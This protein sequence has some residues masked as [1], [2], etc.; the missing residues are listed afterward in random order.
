MAWRYVLFAIGGV[1]A[2]ALVGVITLTLLGV[3]LWGPGT[4][5]APADPPSVAAPET[6]ALT[7]EQ[8]AENPADGD[9]PA[10]AP[11]LAEDPEGSQAGTGDPTAPDAPPAEPTE[12][13]NQPVA[14]TR[15][16][17]EAPPPAIVA[18]P[19]APSFD[20]VRV[21]SSRT[22]VI[23]GRANPRDR[24]TVY[25][26]ETALGS[27]VAD[28]RGE[29][30]VVPGEAL[31]PGDYSLTLEAEPADGD[32]IL[33]SQTEVLLVVPEPFSDV[34]GAQ[35]PAGSAA[36]ALEV[37]RGGAAGAEVLQGPGGAGGQ[38]F[39][40]QSLDITASDALVVAGTAPADSPVII[41]LDGAPMGRV[42][43]DAEGRWRWQGE[44]EI[45]GKTSLI[46]AE[47]ELDGRTTR[48][49]RRID[50]T[51]IEAALPTGRLV[52]VQPGNN[53]WRIARRT[54][55]EGLNYT[56][57][58]EANRDRIENP[59]LIFPGQAFTI[60]DEALPQ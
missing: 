60:P 59:D 16:P 58:F 2:G 5:P 35:A 53:L 41:A 52:I 48:I 50:L 7:A 24:V 27:A 43:S 12:P 22:A 25:A 46:A 10:L 21:G 51:N 11:E 29:W 36:V 49:Q 26:G 44:A 17:I 47:T 15:T 20:I 40:L 19:V 33:V 14:E 34:A 28:G 1:A 39:T 23:A 30:V 55:G 57:I 32:D 31:A 13:A 6:P 37:D 38:G 9:N 4:P 45:F 54:L 8:T 3:R 18:E 56:L 42:T